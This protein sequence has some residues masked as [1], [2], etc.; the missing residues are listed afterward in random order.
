[1]KEKLGVIAVCL[2]LFFSM[3]TLN[4]YLEHREKEN[5]E[6]YEDMDSANLNGTLY[7]VFIVK[8]KNK[9]MQAMVNEKMCTFT[10]KKKLD[11]TVKN[12]VA[13]VDVEDGVVS[14]IVLKEDTIHGKVLAIG[15]DTMEIEGYGELS[16]GKGYKVYK[17]YDSLEQKEKKD[18]L[19]GYD[20]T[21][22]VV[23]DGEVCAALIKKPVKLA[24]IRVLLKNSGQTDNYHEKVSI[25]CDK[26]Y[27]VLVGKKKTDYKK[28]KKLTFST[29]SSEF[30]KEK[31]VQITPQKG[32]KVQVLSISR[33]G[34]HPCY[35]GKI[36]INRK[37]G[38][39]LVL[40][41]E[42]PIE[43]YLYGV[44][45]SEMP[46]SYG[47][48]ALKVQAVCARSYAYKQLLY[49]G[50]GEFGAH[51]DDSVSYQ[52][53]NLSKECKETIE[54][55]DATK[56][57]VLKYEGEVIS[58]YY[59]STSCGSTAS[60]SD[61]WM[62]ED[63]E[64]Y[65]QGKI[66]N[67]KGNEMDFSEEKEFGTFIQNG[68]FDS[69][70]REFPWYRWRVTMSCKSLG[71]VINANLYERCEKN[72]DLILKKQKDG[73]FVSQS[74]DDIGEVRNIKVLERGKSGVVKSI[75]ITGSKCTI[76]VV[77]EYNIRILCAPEH[78]TIYRGDGSQVQ[79]M[80]MLPSGFFNVKQNKKKG[81]FL[82][83]GGGYGHGVGM[84]QNGAKA[85]V[86]AGYHY[87]EILRHYYT[88]VDVVQA[89]H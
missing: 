84:S 44:I 41:N 86:E 62:G 71:Q 15:E 18:V 22:F 87:D 82:F 89:G 66:Q 51:V 85:M 32:G 88:G 50:C 9:K 30:S 59:F 3:L 48:E 63:D 60:A 54:A 8:G 73:S 24:N 40:I 1:M 28:G 25:T 4:V 38:N 23:A 6:K 36:E 68:D 64:V 21:D 27:T 12:V 75:Q 33:N 26:D 52:V 61:V 74:V 53:Y 31:R 83:T 16:F 70:D 13:D 19:I 11:Q 46:V 57:E 58:A 76:K 55:V 39:G 45:G 2:L 43:E 47:K 10:L 7:N 5:I 17:T 42:L 72:Q 35:R 34:E 80:S 69:F 29:E 49:G 79:G 77:S 20:V 78:A 56:G 65:L 14:K 81:T 37:K 67:K